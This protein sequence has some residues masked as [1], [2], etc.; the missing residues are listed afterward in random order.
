MGWD[1]GVRVLAGVGKF[2]E[3]LPLLSC[4]A[5]HGAGAAQQQNGTWLWLRPAGSDMHH[6]TT[7]AAQ[8]HPP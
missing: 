8:P 1:E 2:C 5:A 6:P 7:P 3:P 4:C